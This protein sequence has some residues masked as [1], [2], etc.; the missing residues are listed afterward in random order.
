MQPAVVDVICDCPDEMPAA[1]ACATALGGAVNSPGG[2]ALY[3][4]S[5]SADGV[6]L[7]S[8]AAGTM[9]PVK[10]SFT[11]GKAEHRRRFGGG[12][13]QPIAKAIGLQGL[14]V[15]PHVFDATAGL[16]GDA[17]VL[18]S[19]GCRVT[20]AER[21]PV[22]H[23]LLRDGLGRAR[24]VAALE[25]DTILL[26]IL[27]NLTLLAGDSHLLLAPSDVFVADIIYLD[28]MFPERGK[29]AAVKKEMQAFHHLIGDDE[30]AVTLLEL[31]L[32]AAEY[33]VVVKRP[34]LVEPLG[35]RAPGHQLIGKSTR[36][37]IYPIKGLSKLGALNP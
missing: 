10:V 32:K 20:M 7:R 21:S 29:S 2:S 17:F 27:D 8:I 9:L 11:H 37:D 36:F 33:R 12:K 28:P 1:L 5:F 25:A 30:D 13:G 24:H 26:E 23:A 3:Q 19:L 15:A 22:A 14:R 35:G 6:S 31:A 4:L 34:R 18:A 16:G